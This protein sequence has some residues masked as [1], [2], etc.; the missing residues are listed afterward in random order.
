M[1]RP[2]RYLA[3]LL[4]MASLLFAQLALAAYV[5]PGMHAGAT[6][7]AA[8]ASMPGCDG[9]DMDQP[10]LCH[11]HQQTGNQSLDKPDLPAVQPFTPGALVLTLAPAPLAAQPS[12]EVPAT[13]HLS[14]ATAPP[15]AIQHCCFRI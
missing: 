3:A 2:V 6:V 7:A 4:T 15:L 9:M 1:S 5:C 12:F 8:M 14:H 10:A 13:L 11:A